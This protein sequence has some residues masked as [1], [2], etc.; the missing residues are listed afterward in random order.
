LKGAFVP[1][2]LDTILNQTLRLEYVTGEITHFREISDTGWRNLPYMILSYQKKGTCRFSYK[3]N[4][5]KHVNA[6][7]LIIIPASVTHRTISQTDA[8]TY[9][10]IHIN[11]FVMNNIDLFSFV[12]IPSVFGGK[13]A[14]RIGEIIKNWILF[15]RQAQPDEVIR[16]NARKNEIG[17]QILG[18]LSSLIKPFP[19]NQSKLKYIHQIQPA[20]DRIHHDYV[21]LTGRDELAE[22]CNLSASQFHRIFALAMGIAPMEYVRNLRIRRAQQLLITTDLTIGEITRLAGYSD[23]F[24]FSRYFKHKSGL[25]PE[26]YRR[27]IK[28]S[29]NR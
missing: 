4:P 9:Y 20:L 5:P 17:F 13:I 21:N 1:R 12:E 29:L 27:N 3:D 8:S 25:S 16:V 14:S 11:Y 24:I 19:E 26:H 7:E 15:S 10:W 2:P 18:E 6:N 28:L 22:C 23:P